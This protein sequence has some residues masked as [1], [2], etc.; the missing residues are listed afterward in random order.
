MQ[1]YYVC[2]IMSIIME[3]EK[4]REK[5]KLNTASLIYIIYLN[6]ECMLCPKSYIDNS[7]AT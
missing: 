1:D 5:S 4:E 3:A 2:Q 7:T 6:E